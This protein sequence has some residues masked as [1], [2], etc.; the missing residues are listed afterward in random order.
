[1]R[2]ELGANTSEIATAYVAVRHLFKLRDLW[3]E[4]ESLDNRITNTAQTE[5]LLLVRGWVE[6]GVHWLVKNRRSHKGP[7]DIINK[8]GDSINELRSLI[9]DSLAKPNRES[10]QSR[11]K[12]FGKSGAPE[13]LAA[14]VASV[15]PLS[16]S[17]D[18]LEIHLSLIHISEP[19]RPY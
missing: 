11:C 10:Y 4:I 13:K 14:K 6:R 12:Y 19:T 2:D 9:P 3:T 18:I 16:S 1:M 5:M 17:F 15:V 7:E 8:F